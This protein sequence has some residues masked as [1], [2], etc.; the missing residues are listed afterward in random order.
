M[1]LHAYRHA[2]LI[3]QSAR[4]TVFEA[5]RAM[6]TNE[7]GCIVVVDSNGKIAGLVTDRDIVLRVVGETRD[8]AATS[9]GEVMSPDVATLHPDAE[10]ADA[11]RLMRTRRIRR[12]PL[13]E[14]GRVVGM[15]TIDDLLFDEAASLEEIAAV[16]QAQL[17]ETGPARTRRFDEWEAFKRRYARA[18]A[19]KTKLVVMVQNAARLKS[20]KRGERALWIVLAAIVRRL[21]PAQAVKVVAQLP[22]L[23]RA[24]LRELPPGP[25]ASITRATVEAEVARELEVARSRAAA[26]VEGVGHA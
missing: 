10:T 5:A 2:R 11:L 19:T 13:V 7:I 6:K 16:V 23:Y 3:V 4:T 25:D 15:V 18:E 26:I 24:R 12:V 21:T 17:I 22:L 9:L 8:P 20:R 1:S 14:D